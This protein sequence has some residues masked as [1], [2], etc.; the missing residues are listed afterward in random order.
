MAS[1]TFFHSMQFEMLKENIF[2]NRTWSL[3]P[4][5]PRF[6]IFF[7]TTRIQINQL[8]IFS[9]WVVSFTRAS[10]GDPKRALRPRLRKRM[11]SADVFGLDAV[12]FPDLPG[13]TQEVVESAR[14]IPGS[15]ELLLQRDATEPRFKALPLSDFRIM[16]LA[17]HGVAN[18]AF[19]VARSGGNRK[20]RTRLPSSRCKVCDRKSLARRRHLHRRSHEADVSASC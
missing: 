5:R 19:E 15:T 13:S 18:T 16:H 11:Y 8:G 20:S 10:L 6:C 2:S 9:G 12:M 7:E 3:M 17:V 14:T 1:S 4:H